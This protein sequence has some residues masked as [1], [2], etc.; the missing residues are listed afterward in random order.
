MT[1]NHQNNANGFCYIQGFISVV[2]HFT[3]DCSVCKGIIFL[4]TFPRNTSRIPRK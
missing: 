3:N 4:G 1:Y 2:P